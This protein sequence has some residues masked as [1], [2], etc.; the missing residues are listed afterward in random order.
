MAFKWEGFL[1]S[2]GIHY[3]TTGPNVSRGAIAIRCPWCGSNDPSEHLVIRLNGKGWWCWREKKHRGSKAARLIMGL[4]GCSLEQALGISGE[5]R[6]YLPEGD[7]LGSMERLLNPVAGASNRGE[8][9]LSLPPE[10][11]PIGK[12]ALHTLFERYLE[13]DRGFPYG[14][15]FRMSEEYGIRHCIRGP[16][17]R[18]VIFPVHFMGELVGW[19]GRAIDKSASI[20]YKTLSYEKEKADKEGYPPASGPINNYLLWYDK[21]IEESFHNRKLKLCICEGP[22][23]AL[24]VNVLG[25]RKGIRATCVFTSSP[26]REQTEILYELIPRFERAY[27]FFDQGMTHQARRV[28]SEL[29]ALRVGLL[30]PPERVGDPG[31]LQ[32]LSDLEFT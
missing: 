14:S 6:G 2:R 26:T 1:R 13:E 20:R 23:D 9:P 30:E 21:L 29:S 7:F 12:G 15:I 3:V 18:R 27:I 16:Y 4:I 8:T 24:K 31:E 32:T 22:M 25:E 17:S 11:R 5:D 19:T 28:Q 10:F